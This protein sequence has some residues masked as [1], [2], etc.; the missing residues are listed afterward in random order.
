M[1]LFN[2]FTLN[3]GEISVIPEKA[4][5]TSSDFIINSQRT[6]VWEGEKIQYKETKVED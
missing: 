3:I 4:V 6:L 2:N 1:R 5:L